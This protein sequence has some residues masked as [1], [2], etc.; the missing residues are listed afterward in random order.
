MCPLRKKKSKALQMLPIVVG[1]GPGTHGLESTRLFSSTC[2]CR[3]KARKGDDGSVSLLIKWR[4]NIGSYITLIP[5]LMLQVY[6]S[7]L[8]K[9]KNNFP[10][11]LP[12]S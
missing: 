8:K 9:K 5:K 1:F 7:Y 3:Y 2:S 12:N 6:L 10:N 4:N 11:S